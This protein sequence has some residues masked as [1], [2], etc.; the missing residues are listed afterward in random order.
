MREVIWDT[1]FKGDIGIV[2]WPEKFIFKGIEFVKQDSL[3]MEEMFL[4]CSYSNEANQITLT[5]L[6]A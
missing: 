6:D 5:V 2:G 1:E 4:G 3:F